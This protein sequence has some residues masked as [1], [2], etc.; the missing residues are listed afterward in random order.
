MSGGWTECAVDGG[1]VCGLVY[2]AELHEV[3]KSGLINLL[4]TLNIVELLIHGYSC[5]CV[6]SDLFNG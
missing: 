1:T 4:K 5:V 2:F 3:R 6:F